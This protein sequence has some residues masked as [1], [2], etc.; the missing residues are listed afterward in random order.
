MIKYMTT[1]FSCL[2]LSM[3]IAPTINYTNAQHMPGPSVE[4]LYYWEDY[5]G[6]GEPYAHCAGMPWVCFLGV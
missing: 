4:R 5:A 1:V 3:F 2:L 6:T